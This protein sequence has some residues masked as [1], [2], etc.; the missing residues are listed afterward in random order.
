MQR[1]VLGVIAVGLVVFGVLGSFTDVLGEDALWWGGV[2]LRTGVLL[3]VFWLVM[4]RAT[5]VPRPVWAGVVVFAIVVAVRPR[6][7]LFGIALSFIAM[8]AMA[9]VQRR[10]AK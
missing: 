4:P 8:V 2:T 10:V 9:I 7:V 6:L 1:I 3:G 5:Q